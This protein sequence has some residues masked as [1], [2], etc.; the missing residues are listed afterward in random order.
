MSFTDFE[1]IL[2]MQGWAKLI[3]IILIISNFIIIFGLKFQ[4]NIITKI[5]SMFD[6]KDIKK[7]ISSTKPALL[8]ITHPEDELTYWSPTIKTLI[9]YNI[10]LKILC[11]STND[12]NCEKIFEEIDNNKKFEEISK[13]LKLEDNKLVHIPSYE[14]EN[15]S[16]EIKNF[17][18]NNED[19][20]TI[21]TFDENGAGNI[22]HVNCYFGLEL[23][24]KNNREEIKKKGIKIFL[25]DSFNTIFKYSFIIPFIFFYFKEFGFVI[26]TC[27]D[28]NKWMKMHNNLCIGFLK[29]ITIFL[30]CYTYFNSFTKVELK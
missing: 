6:I 5:K 7:D 19:I 3:L 13:I 10:K 25:L 20:G 26:T 12:N 28:Y 23:F 18:D 8:I 11:L 14:P 22:E 30:N 17:L 16:K 2:E 1:N 27:F 21:L 24:L 9:N 29:K 4:I 15:I